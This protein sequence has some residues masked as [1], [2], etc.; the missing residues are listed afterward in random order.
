[1]R[2]RELV[3]GIGLVCGL[4]GARLITTPGL[5][6]TPGGEVFGH[7]WVQGWHAAALPA[8]P[9]GTELALGTD[10]WPVIDPLI[11]GLVAL[12]TRLGG[13]GLGYNAWVL[14]AVAMAFGGG[15][16]LARREG[17]DPW[18]GGLA[19]A[20]APAWLGA[21]HSGLTEDGAVGLA[22]VGLGL[23]GRGGW[24]GGLAAGLALG[25]L[26][27]CGLVL[28][29]ISGVAAVG[30]GLGLLWRDRG[31]WKGLLLGGLVALLVASPLMWIHGERLLG[32]GH[33]LGTWQAE[34]EPLWRLNPWKG[35]DLASFVVPG[36]QD[37]GDALV[38][39]HPGYLGLVALV[40]AVVGGW[41][42]WWLV[43]A[44][45][46][47]VA[48]GP[49]LGLFGTPI[50]ENPVFSALKWVPGGDLL[51]HHGR[52]LILG[53]VALAVLAARGAVALK[54]RAPMWVLAGAV[55]V[56]FAL[57]SPVPLPLATVP[58]SPQGSLEWCDGAEQTCADLDDLSPGAML[59]LPLA[60]PGVHFQRPLLDQRLHGRPLLLDPNRPGLPRGLRKTPVGRWLGGLAFGTDAPE[61]P[62]E[63]PEPVAVLLVLEPYVDE[64]E[65]VLG[66]PD[67][68][69]RPG[70]VGG[71][72]VWDVA[73]RRVERDVE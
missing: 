73:A 2:R 30:L 6:A 33:R 36:R 31:A 59:V 21:L 13:I 58:L 35:V 32:E 9:A 71:S 15:A 57:L 37:A 48:P 67:L 34:V 45:C 17:G 62:I 4:V 47:L 12:L 51:N 20:L 55:V 65:V 53:A 40:L 43:L 54:G 5:L 10:P 49:S 28:A 61:G 39:T 3:L 14:G 60:G 72:A 29:W 18:V 52:V 66:S 7:A 22:A 27:W 56:D 16:W 23:V 68:V 11:T 26:A 50:V 8:W 19:L 64:A 25:L 38:R 46:V 42:R 69:F 63:I 41:S 24:R 1:M 44:V 70:Q